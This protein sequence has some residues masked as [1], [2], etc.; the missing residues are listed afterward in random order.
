M[1]L[2]IIVHYPKDKNALEELYKKKSKLHTNMILSYINKLP[3]S[4]D[5]KIKLIDRIQNK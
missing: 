5:E 2:N 1:E 4:K 3:Y